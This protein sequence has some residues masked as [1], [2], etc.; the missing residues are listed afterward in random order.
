MY[1]ALV[2]HHFIYS[3][4]A[5]AAPF[6]GAYAA[7]FHTALMQHR[8]TWRLYSTISYGAYSAPFHVALMQHL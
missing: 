2:Q 1:M 5:S 8:F 3:Y 6:P 7:P 4:S